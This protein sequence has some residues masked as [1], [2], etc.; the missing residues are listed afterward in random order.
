VARKRPGSEA[1]KAARRASGE[2][3]NADDA[4]QS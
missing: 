4:A 3:P 2:Q 1:D